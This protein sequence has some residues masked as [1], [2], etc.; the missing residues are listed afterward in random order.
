MWVWAI[1][2]YDI[3]MFVFMD[4]WAKVRGLALLRGCSGH[5]VRACMLPLCALCA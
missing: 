5:A 3:D 1:R 4:D 2:D